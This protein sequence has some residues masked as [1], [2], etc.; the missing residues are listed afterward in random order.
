[1]I[2][3]NPGTAGEMERRMIYKG[4]QIVEQTPR[5]RSMFNGGPLGRREF[6]VRDFDTCEW[7]DEIFWTETEAK[8]Y[9]DNIEQG[10]A[11]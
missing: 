11:E 6:H 7:H 2:Q 8:Q 10:D 3:D 5:S 9:I 1:M 4:H